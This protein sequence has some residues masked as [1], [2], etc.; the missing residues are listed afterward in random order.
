M[1]DDKNA[2]IKYRI[3]RAEETLDEVKLAIE[4]NRLHLAANRIYYSVFYIVSSLALKK[5]FTTSK[6][7]QLLG[8]FN[9][10]IVKAGLVDKKLGKFYLDAFEMRQE[11]DY[12][13]LVSF[14]LKYIKDKF[15]IAQ[16][17]INRIKEIIS[18]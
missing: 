12:D 5:D 2:L 7:S 13:D 3:N 17:F 6:H 14:D 11:G 9:R 18:L 8:W 16:E 4:N 1:Q 15:D 10:E